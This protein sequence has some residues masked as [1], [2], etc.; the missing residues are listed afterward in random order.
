MDINSKLKH[1]IELFL[2]WNYNSD[3]ISIICDY[4]HLKPVD[5]IRYYGDESHWKRGF[6]GLRGVHQIPYRCTYCNQLCYNQRHE[7]DLE[8]P[9]MTNC[10]DCNYR[11]TLNSEYIKHKQNSCRT[12]L[13]RCEYCNFRTFRQNMYDHYNSCNK[14]F[15]CD[16][17][18]L[19]YTKNNMNLHQLFC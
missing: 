3:I 7:H 11:G 19:V 10:E 18:D 16:K 9:M 8:C 14:V 5:K 17:C 6:I 15:K 12:T 4:I 2:D 13:I 1:F